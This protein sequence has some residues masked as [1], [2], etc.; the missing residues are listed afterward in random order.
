MFN[1]I[2]KSILN[3]KKG[4]KSTYPISD[5]FGLD[6]GQPIDRYYIE[7]FLNANSKYIHGNVLEIADSEYSKKFG[8]DVNLYQVLSFESNNN[9]TIVGDLTKIETLP[10]EISDCFICTQTFNFIYDLKSAIKGSRQLLKHGG[11]LL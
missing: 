2:K 6:R 4:H 3:R 1:K 11:V 7:K 5:I 8:K 9:T 10:K